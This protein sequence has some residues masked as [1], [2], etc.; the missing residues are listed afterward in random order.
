MM[1]M[2]SG[3][4]DAY[5]Q[6]PGDQ[7]EPTGSVAVSKKMF[8]LKTTFAHPTRLP[9][10]LLSRVVARVPWRGRI[11]VEVVVCSMDMSRIMRVPIVQK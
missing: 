2:F 5:L 4:R 10:L 1:V 6:D 3:E 11:A 8:F 7:F 9:P